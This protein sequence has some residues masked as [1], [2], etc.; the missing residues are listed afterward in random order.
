MVILVLLASSLMWILSMNFLNHLMIYTDDAYGYYKSYYMAKAWLELALTEI[1]NSQ[2]WFSHNITWWNS[3][4]VN[5][6]SC[7]NCDFNMEIIG[8]NSFIS[9]LYWQNSVCNVDS[10]FSLE[11]WESFVLPLFYD[12]TTNE[13]NILKWDNKSYSRL[14]DNSL[15]NL[16]FIAPVESNSYWWSNLNIW[17]VIESGDSVLTDYAFM[18][19]KTI[20]VDVLSDYYI[21]FLGLYSDNN[22]EIMNKNKYY[23]LSNPGNSEIKFCIKVGDEAQ[24]YSLLPWTKFF[25]SSI[26]AYN[27]KD[28]SL[29]AVYA[30]PIPSFF[31]NSF[32]GSNA[33]PMDYNTFSQ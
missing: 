12:N 10:A 31:V 25:V 27:W 14:L 13:A 11:P 6:F 26:G 3:I 33:G 16:K 4:I 1:D 28:V 29:Q 24:K 5:N 23:I 7:G 19:T 22:P 8:R 21:D 17:I 32:F 2:V 9:N 15:K 30:Q 20:N 18:K